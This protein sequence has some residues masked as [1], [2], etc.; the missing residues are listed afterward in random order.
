MRRE[1]EPRVCRLCS[2]LKPL[3]SFPPDNMAICYYCMSGDWSEIQLGAPSTV[4][5]VT[6]EGARDEGAR[7]NEDDVFNGAML[8]P[9]AQNG[10][11][12][13]AGTRRA[14]ERQPIREGA[15]K[16]RCRTPTPQSIT[17]D[18]DESEG[19]TLLPDCDDACTDSNFNDDYEPENALATLEDT[20]L[21]DNSVLSPE[22]RAPS[23]VDT[24]PPAKR[25]T[26]RPVQHKT[27]SV[28]KA[29]PHKGSQ[30]EKGGRKMGKPAIP[31]NQ[32]SKR[33]RGRPKGSVAKPTSQIL[34]RQKAATAMKP[35]VSSRPIQ[36]AS[37]PLLRIRRGPKL[38]TMKNKDLPQRETR[39]RSRLTRRRDG[40]YPINNA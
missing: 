33:G 5:T 20:P 1:P 9:R 21:S 22:R 28:P 4:F 37:Q 7:D 39:A 27:T 35:S 29:R 32:Q 6:D 10:T 15:R 24:Q 38:H 3:R 17:I 26:S 34:E 40:V 2:I 14:R 18:A 12:P 8:H 25:T 16:R 13:A 23:P 19:T 31:P 36:S 30:R 11:P